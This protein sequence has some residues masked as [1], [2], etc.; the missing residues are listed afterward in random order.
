M[1][2]MPVV[3]AGSAASGLQCCVRCLGLFEIEPKRQRSSVRACMAVVCAGSSLPWG[4]Y[5][6]SVAWVRLTLNPND[7]CHVWG[8]AWQPCG[9]RNLEVVMLCMLLVFGSTWEQMRAVVHAGVHARCACG[10]L[11]VLVAAVLCLLLGFAWTWT[12]MRATVRE[13]VHNKHIEAYWKS[14]IKSF[15]TLINGNEEPLQNHAGTKD[16]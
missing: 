3:F 1:A 16:D 11:A 10:L 13:A 7:G 14:P 2:C 5:I 6:V 15:E 4:C 8:R 12:Q 9:F